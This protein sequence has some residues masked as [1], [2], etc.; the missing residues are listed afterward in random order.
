[1][2]PDSLVVGGVRGGASELTLIDFLC[3]VSQT[4]HHFQ[5]HLKRKV[6]V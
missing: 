4:P 1:M 6:S 2:I 3:P 5:S